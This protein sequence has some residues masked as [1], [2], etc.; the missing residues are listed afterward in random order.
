DRLL[1]RLNVDLGPEASAGLRTTAILSPD[2]TR[3]VFPIRNAN[4]VRQLAT[5]TLDQPKATA[6][7]GTEG[8]IDAFFSPDG[9][10]IAF[11][12]DGKLKKAPVQGGAPV[13]LCDAADPRG[14]AW[15][16]DGNIVFSPAAASTLM[17]V[18]SSGGA[19]QPLTKMDD[20]RDI[21]RWPQVLPGAKGVLF[22]MS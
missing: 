6:M 17:R 14:G 2:G 18:S 13:T 12:A 21:Y 5:R 9:Q 22:T 1:I 11:F 20:P 4:G 8:G 16:D 19:P 15:G 7:A 3:I 10:W